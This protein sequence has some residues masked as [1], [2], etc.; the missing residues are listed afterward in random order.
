MD[1][2][3]LS[4]AATKKKFEENLNLLKNEKQIQNIH[5]KISDTVDLQEVVKKE[6]DCTSNEKPK[7]NILKVETPQTVT[8]P[9]TEQFFEKLR[10]KAAPSTPCHQ[11]PTQDPFINRSLLT[12]MYPTDCSPFIKLE[13]SSKA[14]HIS[15]PKLGLFITSILCKLLHYFSK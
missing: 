6:N 3:A 2:Q 14:P 7:K 11:T 12:S 5:T 1:E 4:F 8:P 10:K 13:F 15:Q 9:P